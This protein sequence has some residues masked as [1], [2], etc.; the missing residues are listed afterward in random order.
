MEKNILNKE[1]EPDL[2]TVQI[3]I[4]THSM[5]I[6]EMQM[7]YSKNFSEEKIH[8]Q[9]FSMM[10]MISLVV[11]VS[12]NL[13][14]ECKWDMDSEEWGDSVKWIT[15]KINKEEVE[16]LFLILAWWEE[17]LMMKMI[18]LAVEVL[19]VDSVEVKDLLHFN[20]AVLEVWGEEWVNL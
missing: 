12:D 13:V 8:S 17:D 10:M 20:L 7:I 2:I 9:I 4:T 14:E 3:M 19:G 6:S 5:E 1:V 11:E 18:S 16:I 15:D